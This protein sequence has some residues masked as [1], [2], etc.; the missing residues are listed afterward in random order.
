M[1]TNKLFV[2]IIKKEETLY[3]VAA[4]SEDKITWYS[5]PE[6][7]RNLEKHMLIKE[8]KNV[9][10]SLK[11]ISKIGGFRK[12]GINFSKEMNI[13][14]CDDEGNFSNYDELEEENKTKSEIK[15]N[16]VLLKK[17]EEL[18]KKIEEQT[19][20]NVSDIKNKFLLETFNGKQEAKS[21]IQNFEKE[22]R[23]FNINSNERK[24]EILKQF[25][26]GNP[27]EW[28]QANVIKL[29]LSEWEPW[30][31]SFLLTFKKLDWS[32]IRTAFSFKYIYGSIMEYVIKK[33]R[34]L[35]EA[36]KNF[37][38]LARIYQIIYGLPI[39]IQELLDREKIRDINS[40]ITELKKHK[41][42][43]KIN[44]HF[45]KTRG[46]QETTVSNLSKKKPCHICEKL[47]Y[48]ERYHPIQV[49]R[50]KNKNFYIN[51]INLTEQD[52]QEMEPEKEDNL[53]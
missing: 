39:P 36:D 42:I 37:P 3:H 8:N 13:F 49:C 20:P 24:I 2:H 38:E 4:I 51:R 12:L 47:G 43:Y 7:E 28:Y 29:K 15:H 44:E 9:Q 16:N 14:Y 6:E 17:I 22:C 32:S 33:E 34:L 53:N 11:T 5:I 25:L 19:Q 18:E 50:N 41:D 46:K 40:L 1:A 48:S 35:L 30:I 10:N 31:D 26:E 23:R 21:W 27:L 45:E 52:N